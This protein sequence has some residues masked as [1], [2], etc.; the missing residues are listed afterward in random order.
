MGIGGSAGVEETSNEARPR[1]WQDDLTNVI[2]AMDVPIRIF[3][4]IGLFIV[5]GLLAL[6]GFLFLWVY[7][8]IPL[9]LLILSFITNGYAWK[10]LKIYLMEIYPS[11]EKNFEKLVKDIYLGGGVTSKHWLKTLKNH[12]VRNQLQKMRKT[13]IWFIKGLSVT[14][15]SLFILALIVSISKFLSIPGSVMEVL[16]MS[17]VGLAAISFLFSSYMLIRRRKLKRNLK[18]TIW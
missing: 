2:E 6:L 12:S 15:Y 18:S 3:D 4:E 16:W 9:L 11:S 5:I 10:M 1:K 13:H 8:T 14:S 17:L 7:I